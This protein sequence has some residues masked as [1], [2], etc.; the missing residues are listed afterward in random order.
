MMREAEV[1]FLGTVE[2]IGGSEVVAP[3]VPAGLGSR[4]SHRTRFSVIKQWRGPR[5]DRVDVTLLDLRQFTGVFEVG[6]KYLVFAQWRELG[7]SRSRALVPSGY[8]Q[9]VYRMVSDDEARNPVNGTVNVD[10]LRLG[11]LV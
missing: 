7:T 6:T 11:L 2:E 4:S 1:V 10:K 3:D 5:A 9:G 8:D